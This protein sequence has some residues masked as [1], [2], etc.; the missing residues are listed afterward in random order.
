M[1]NLRMK[2]GTGVLIHGLA[3]ADQ[4]DPS[5]T[6]LTPISKMKNVQIGFQVLDLVQPGQFDFRGALNVPELRAKK[7]GRDGGGRTSW[8]S[9][10]TLYKLLKY[11]MQRRSAPGCG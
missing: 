10:S 4:F 9:C 3:P 7:E 11:C 1:L 5:Q 8:L 6:S 2:G